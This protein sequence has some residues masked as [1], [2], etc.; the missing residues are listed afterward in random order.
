MGL[1]VLGSGDLLVV[2]RLEA[3]VR[4]YSRDGRL[5]EHL[6]PG[7]Q[8]SQPTDVLEL[9]SG[10]VVVRDELGLQLFAEDG[11]FL[12]NLGL[13]IDR[14]F[15]LAEDEGRLVTINCNEGQERRH[16]TAPGQTDI[17]YLD[18]ASDKIVKRVELEDIIAPEEKENSRCR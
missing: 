16:V 17:F 15:G 9:R 6:R 7:R 8:F 13:Q 2:C 18:V 10:Q 4:R 5:K 14:C 11:K 3:A 1:S 12:R